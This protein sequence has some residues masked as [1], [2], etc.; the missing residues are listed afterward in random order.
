[1]GAAQNLI[2]SETAVT[3]AME[4]G[5]PESS[6]LYLGLVLL[7]STVLY[8]VPKTNVIGAVL[9]TAWLGSAVATHVM[10]GKEGKDGNP[11]NEVR[12]L[13]NSIMENDGKMA[14]ERGTLSNI[15]SK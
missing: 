4:M 2:Q 7:I 15:W 1:M 14:E 13:C 5:Y 9:L 10:R 11:L 3:G 8:A 6:V 12:M